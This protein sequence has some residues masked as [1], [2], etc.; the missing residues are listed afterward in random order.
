[1]RGKAVKSPFCSLAFEW[2]IG[3]SFLMPVLSSSAIGFNTIITNN[4]RV[5]GFEL[6]RSGRDRT[7]FCFYLFLFCVLLGLC[8]AL[9]L[10]AVLR[11]LVLFVRGFSDRIGLLAEFSLMTV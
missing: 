5:L 3:C 9:P 11:A 10:W 1:M 8:A 6:D 4:Q 7:S 2:L